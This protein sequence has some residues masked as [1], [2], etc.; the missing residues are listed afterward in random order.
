[1]YFCQF[2]TSDNNLRWLV[3]LKYQAVYIFEF[4]VSRFCAL[5]MPKGVSLEKRMKDIFLCSLMYAYFSN[6]AKLVK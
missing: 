1:M 5:G 2:F 6:N 3:S 4:I